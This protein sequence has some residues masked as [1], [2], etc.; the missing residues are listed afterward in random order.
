MERAMSRAPRHT[1]QYDVDLAS[2]TAPA[3][4]I[5]MTG[6]GKKVLEIGAGPGSITRHLSGTNNC[7]VVAV[8]LD[9]SAIEHLTPFCRRVYGLDLNDPQWP[10]ELASEGKFDVV[11]AADVLEHLYNPLA[12]LR[13]M[14]SLL[15][16][17]GAII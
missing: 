8:E 7:D 14:R 15:N 9:P 4:V 12:T 10:H 13:G 1:Y 11:I 6:R 17:E 5:R 16:D 3:R 2:D